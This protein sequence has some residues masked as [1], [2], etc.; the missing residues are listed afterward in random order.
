MLLAIL[1]IV[2]ILSIRCLSPLEFGLADA[3]TGLQRYEV[4]LKTH[5]AAIKM[6]AGVTYAGISVIDLDIPQS[7]DA[8]PL[9]EYTDFAG[10]V[11]NVT[12][13][14]NNCYLFEIVNGLERIVLTKDQFSKEGIS[15]IRELKNGLHILIVEDGSPWVKQRR[16]Y[17]YGVNRK[18]IILVDN[19]VALN[20]PIQPYSDSFSNPQFQIA[21]VS[22]TATII[23]GLTLN[24][25]GI[26]KYMTYL[27]KI[28]NTNNIRFQDITIN[29]PKETSLTG[30][31]L[32]TIKN[33]SNV[34]FDNVVINGT[35]SSKDQFGYGICLDN[36]WNSHFLR[37]KTTSDWGVFGNN[38]IN[39]SVIEDCDI[40]RYDVHCYG[41]DVYAINS[42][43]RD[44][45]NQ[46]SS[47]Y[48]I[49][50][51]RNCSFT[52][53]VPVLFEPSYSSYTFFKL[54]IKNCF[55]KV[56]KSR[57]YLIR[58]GSPS[59][60]DANARAEL[61]KVS[62]PNISIDSLTVV[63][64]RGV[65]DWTLFHVSGGYNNLIYGIDSLVVKNTEIRGVNNDV[66]VFFSNRKIKTRKSLFVSISKSSFDS[67]RL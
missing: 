51:F 66:V 9:G 42:K 34:L 5:R 40:N 60:V 22:A 28:Y 57:P 3:D 33:C 49:L 17:K 15:R 26:S 18:D 64:P 46:F 47:L 50:S 31:R 16:G 52:D 38:N 24:R 37:L 63:L 53:F 54:E 21:E 65:H 55:L 6:K 44:L 41:R 23:K 48:G 13:N 2:S 14:V 32:F 19:G 20:S 67:I 30:D 36:V 12:N 61:K 35:Y 39:Y 8:I 29:T 58:A 62:W 56:D 7:S 10:A 45:Y 43:F 59:M 1:H 25:T 4:L 11:I 27:C